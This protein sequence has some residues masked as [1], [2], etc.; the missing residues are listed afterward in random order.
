MVFVLALPCGTFL[1]QQGEFTLAF[2]R[3]QEGDY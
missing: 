1:L 2:D 3:G